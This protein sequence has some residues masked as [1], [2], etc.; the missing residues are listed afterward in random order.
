MFYF[1]ECLWFSIDSRPS[2][3]Q[4]VTAFSKGDGK[5]SKKTAAL[6]GLGATGNL[7]SVM[8]YIHTSSLPKKTEKGRKGLQSQEKSLLACLC[9]P[10]PLS[11]LPSIF[12]GETYSSRTNT[13]PHCINPNWLGY[14]FP[15]LLSSAWHYHLPLGNLQPPLLI[16]SCWQLLHRRAQFAKGCM[17]W[18]Y[19]DTASDLAGELR[20]QTMRSCCVRV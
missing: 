12:N 14:K 8:S 2:H 5:E 19:K 3:H 11:N 10:P 13:F 6:M 7:Q 16:D 1:G 20:T 15:L 18:S 4:C 9:F 17:E